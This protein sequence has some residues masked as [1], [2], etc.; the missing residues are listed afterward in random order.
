MTLI[1]RIKRQGSTTSF[2]FFLI[3]DLGNVPIVKKIKFVSCLQAEIRR[4]VAKSVSDLSDLV[5]GHYNCCTTV[6]L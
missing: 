3:S 2:R 5:G 6:Q 4:K 1:F